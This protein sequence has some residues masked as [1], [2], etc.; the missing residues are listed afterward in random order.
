MS[1]LNEMDGLIDG[2]IDIHRYK[3]GHV[4]I[5]YSSIIFHKVAKFVPL[6][7]TQEDKAHSITPGKIGSVFFFPAASYQILKGKPAKWGYRTGFGRNEHLLEVKKN[8]E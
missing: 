8:I 2:W 1:D 3:A 5:F 7:Q 4:C 6:A